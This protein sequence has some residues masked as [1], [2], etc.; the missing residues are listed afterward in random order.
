MGLDGHVIFVSFVRHFILRAFDKITR[1]MTFM[2]L[3]RQ[4]SP[5]LIDHY[6]TLNRRTSINLFSPTH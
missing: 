6:A 3:A 1:I 5:S 2:Q 4:I